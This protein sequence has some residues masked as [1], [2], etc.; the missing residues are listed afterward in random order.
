MLT[1]ELHELRHMTFRRKGDVIKRRIVTMQWAMTVV[2]VRLVSN[3]CTCS[4]TYMYRLFNSPGGSTNLV[5]VV[6]SILIVLAE[7]VI[8]LLTELVCFVIK[9]M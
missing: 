1:V 7:T 4:D 5:H 9:C 8:V 2:N 6:T 3:T